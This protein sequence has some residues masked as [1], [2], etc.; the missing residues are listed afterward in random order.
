LKEGRPVFI[1]KKALPYQMKQSG[2]GLGDEGDQ[3][4]WEN[5]VNVKD[6][7]T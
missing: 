3:A 6:V 7:K 2:S 1:R 5:E 4:E